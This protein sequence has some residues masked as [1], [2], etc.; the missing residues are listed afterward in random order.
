MVVDVVGGE[1][2]GCVSLRGGR[3]MRLGDGGGCLNQSGARGGRKRGR[4]S[5][6][7]G[8]RGVGP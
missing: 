6:Q 8:K 1:W 3:G 4:G 2:R 7:V 5:D